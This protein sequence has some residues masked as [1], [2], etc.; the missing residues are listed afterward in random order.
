MT[1]NMTPTKKAKIVTWKRE[2]HSYQWICKHVTGWNEISDH[3][4]IQIF[5]RYNEKEN[6][7]DVEH[8]TGHPHKMNKREMHNAAR[9]L[10]SGR[11]HDTTH[12]RED[13]FPDLYVSKVGDIQIHLIT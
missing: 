3:Q 12:L 2:R 13:I 10:A 11:A 6:Y 5:N 9:Q 7:C 4:I 8:K 1:P